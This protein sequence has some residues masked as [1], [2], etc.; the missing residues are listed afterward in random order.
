MKK[1]MML[2]I[3]ILFV[4]IV[5]VDVKAYA[6]F[7]IEK[8]N[9]IEYYSQNEGSSYNYLPTEVKRGDIITVKVYTNMYDYPRTISYG[10]YSIRW[11]EEA[12]E[13]IENNGKYY[14][15]KNEHISVYSEYF[16]ESNVL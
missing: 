8:E 6:T 13:L 14:D 5:S 12:F 7:E 4:L 10:N 11:D 2:L 15:L 1:K 16:N 9:K 3:T